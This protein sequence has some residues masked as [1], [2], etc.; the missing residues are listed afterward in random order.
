MRFEPTSFVAKRKM[1]LSQNANCTFSKAAVLYF[2]LILLKITLF[3]ICLQFLKR[4]MVPNR[5][6]FYESNYFLVLII[7]LLGSRQTY[8]RN[9]EYK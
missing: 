7:K 8:A 4:R 6:T 9:R 2:T 5:E 3:H 1:Y